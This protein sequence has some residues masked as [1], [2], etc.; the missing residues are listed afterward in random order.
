MFKPAKTIGDCLRTL[1]NKAMAMYLSNTTQVAYSVWLRLLDA[2]ADSEVLD[3]YCKRERMAD[4][5]EQSDG[6]DC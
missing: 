6:C 1:D 3:K 5:E 4:D 2:P